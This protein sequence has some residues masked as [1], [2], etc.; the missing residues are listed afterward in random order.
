MGR[1]ECSVR[2]LLCQD[3]E[4][5]FHPNPEGDGVEMKNVVLIMT[6]I[7]LVYP[8]STPGSIIRVPEDHLTI[9][10]GI[11]AAID[12]DTVLVDTGTYVETINFNG[13]NIVVGSLYLTT[14]D[15]S[16][17]S[18]TVID[19]DSTGHVV[20]FENGEDSTA[21]LSGFTLTDAFLDWGVYCVQ[22]SPSLFDLSIFGNRGGGLYCK[23]CNLRLKSVAIR[24]NWSAWLGG[25]ILSDSSTLQLEDVEISGN[26][27]TT[28]GGGIYSQGSTLL[29]DN[30]RIVD[31]DTWEGN[32][33]GIYLKDSDLRFYRGS[34][35]GNSAFYSGG[36]IWISD[37]RAVFDS[38]SI[39]KNRCDHGGGGLLAS[40]S[41]IVFKN[42]W[43]ADNAAHYSSGGGFLCTDSKLTVERSVV[44]FNDAKDH[45]GGILLRSTAEFS[46]STDRP[47]SLLVNVTMVGNIASQGGGLFLSNLIGPVVINSI[48]WGNIP[49]EIAF[50]DAAWWPSEVAITHSDLTGG[51]DSILATERDSILWLDGNMDIDPRFADAENRDFDLL[52][53][54]PAIDA[55]TALFIWNGDTLVNLPDKAYEGN[56]PD[57]GAFESPFSTGVAEEDRYPFEFSLKQNY[58]NPFNPSTTIEFSVPRSGLV[59][60]SVYDLL[61]REVEIILNQHMNPGHHK[62]QWNAT[63]VPSGVY[64]VRMKA[65]GFPQ[66][67]KVTVLK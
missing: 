19:A 51:R 43:V 3:G 9:Q 39:T 18:Q 10:A 46:E 56:A 58:P 37:S 15:T 21:V 25:G 52:E 6:G 63:N 50:D 7:F 5:G 30:T 62:V 44:A 42:G 31:N 48:L 49:Q 33:G 64:F 12:G 14:G 13:K 54:S 4:R 65:D 36:G 26:L 35:S 20:T 1:D 53:G 8:S 67:R 17:I 55:G 11:D 47:S 57:M 16:H 38:V 41:D 29:L 2:D 24:N 66:T 60:L 28:S 61:G 34:V 22:S 23:G 40:N 32:A 27:S 59:T 45:G